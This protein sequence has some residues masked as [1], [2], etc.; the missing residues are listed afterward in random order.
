[1]A[2]AA[3]STTPET[4]APTLPGTPRRLGRGPVRQRLLALLAVAAL[5]LG[6]VL[7]LALALVLGVRQGPAPL[8]REELD[9]RVEEQVTGALRDHEQAPPEV[10]VAY[11]TVRP[12]L[13]ELTAE[14][15]TGGSSRR[16]G[17]GVV[18]SSAGSVL[19]ALHVVEGASSIEAR[20]ADGTRARA[21]V[22][23]RRPQHDIAVL[24]VDQLPEVVVPAVLGAAAE[25][26]HPVVAVGHPFGLTGTVTAGV[27]SAL[28]RSLRLDHGA[29]LSGL[30]QFDAAVNPGS[31]GGPLVNGAGQVVGIVTGLANP[32]QQSYFVGIGFAV[33]IATAA[34]AADAPPL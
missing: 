4:S 11:R 23:A 14:V 15:G 7:A 22:V 24:A 6:A 20:F 28:D 16:T 2:G 32:S 30:I 8:S 12:S 1:M 26:G 19:T 25:V 10:A 5:A 33:P 13:V 31:S 18:V 27:V 9:R 21:E 3:P 34:S 29:R 17:A